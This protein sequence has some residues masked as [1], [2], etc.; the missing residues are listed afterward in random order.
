MHGPLN[1]IFT[2]LLQKKKNAQHISDKKAHM[3]LTQM[4]K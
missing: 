1:V 2:T 3:L 4:L